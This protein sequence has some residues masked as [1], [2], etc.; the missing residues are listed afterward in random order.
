MNHLSGGNKRKTS[1]S[2]ENDR[3]ITNQVKLAEEVSVV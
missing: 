3:P 1:P 2:K